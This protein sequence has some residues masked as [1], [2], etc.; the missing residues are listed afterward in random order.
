MSHPNVSNVP[1][2][3]PGE[4]EAIRLEPGR[5]IGPIPVIQPSFW[6]RARAFVL[7]WLA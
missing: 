5:A 6:A 1:A 3:W 2:E 4:Q 7:G